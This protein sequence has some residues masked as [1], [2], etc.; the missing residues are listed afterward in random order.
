[1]LCQ[2]C[3][4]ND[5][6][7]H[8]TEIVDDKVIELHLC[9]DCAKQKGIALTP[10][11]AVSELIST[12]AAGRGTDDDESI[13]CPCCG[14]SLKELRAGGRLGC[15]KCYLTFEKSLKPLIKNL[16]KGTRHIGKMPRGMEP[17]GPG[18]GEQRPGSAA[19][20][21]AAAHPG[22]KDQGPGDEVRRLQEQIRAAVAAEDYETAMKLR[23]R[24]RELES[25]R[26]DD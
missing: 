23:D 10:A 13:T 4:K 18:K 5:V 22:G 11:D 14:L 2:N 15:G 9:E 7:V 20:G 12:F 21:P 25:P 3:K 24:V 19:E 1:M 17:A 26:D 8:F 6:T 16:H